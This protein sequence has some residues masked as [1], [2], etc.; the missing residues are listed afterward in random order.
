MYVYKNGYVGFK[1][2]QGKLKTCTH[3]QN[4]SKNS[5]KAPTQT[6]PGHN[7]HSIKFPPIGGDKWFG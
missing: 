2:V 3:M 1:G 4:E 7:I 6:L 5:M